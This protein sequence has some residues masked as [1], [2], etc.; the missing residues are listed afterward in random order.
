MRFFIWNWLVNL[1]VIAT[2]GSCGQMPDLRSSMLDGIG[3]CSGVAPGPP[4]LQAGALLR[5]LNSR[6]KVVEVVVL[7][8]NAPRSFA[9]KPIALLLSYR[10]KNVVANWRSPLRWGLAEA[11]RV[12][13]PRP[14]RSSRF[15]R[16]IS[17]PAMRAS[18]ECPSIARG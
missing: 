12:E 15:S 2:F 5:E 11:E 6:S 16:P 3:G 17:T 18:V 4:V 9:Y 13:L 10:A 7:L 1:G 14:R 8:G